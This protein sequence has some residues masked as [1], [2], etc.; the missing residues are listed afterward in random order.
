MMVQAAILPASTGIYLILLY[1]NVSEGESSGSRKWLRLQGKYWGSPYREITVR[2][3]SWCS[4]IYTIVYHDYYHKV[5]S[6]LRVCTIYS[7][8]SYVLDSVRVLWY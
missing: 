2:C 7:W 6:F 4:F 8:T 5:K 1:I 3:L